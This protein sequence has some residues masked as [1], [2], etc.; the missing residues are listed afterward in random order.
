M[1]VITLILAPVLWL[2]P[3]MIKVRNRRGNHLISEAVN[4]MRQI[5]LAMFEFQSEYGKYPDADTIDA[6]ESTAGT[7]LPATIQSSNDVF[8]QLIVS[9]IVQN[10]TMFHVRTRDGK[11]PDN[12]MTGSRALEKGETGFSYVSGLSA[13]GNPSRPLIVA[14]LIPGT[15]RFDPGPLDGKAVIFTTGDS[16]KIHQIEKD[17]HVMLDGMNVLD[18]KHPVWAGEG[19][20]LLWPE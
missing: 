14:P 12:V 1:V 13:T 18:P 3:D 11:K 17:G 20:K 15:D 7:D 2:L 19:W 9:G 16:F 4:N 6:V 10:E 8:R 5:G